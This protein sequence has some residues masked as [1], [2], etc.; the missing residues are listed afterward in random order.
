MTKGSKGLK[1]TKIENKLSLRMMQNADV[2]L[3]DVFVPDQ[4]KLTYATD[5]AQGTEKILMGS[6][7]STGWGSA[8]IAAGAYEAALK[9]CLT[10]KQFGKPLAKFQLIQEKLSR[11]LSMLE[12]MLSNLILISQAM[13]K[14]EYTFGQVTRIKSGCSSMSR[15]ICL[16][17]REICGGNGILLENHVMKQMMDIESLHTFEGTYEVNSLIS[18]RELTG[19]MAA[20]K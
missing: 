17:A 9:Y 14:G 15:Q 10:R 8:G 16:M 6:R 18:G 4:N 13:D 2:I 19:G 5:F 20:F 7:L 12:M 11:M 1:T 3:Q